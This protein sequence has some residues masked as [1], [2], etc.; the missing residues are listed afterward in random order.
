M[1]GKILACQKVHIFLALTMY[2]EISKDESYT[3]DE[4]K[5]VNL[6]AILQIKAKFPK[7]KISLWE[8]LVVL[9]ILGQ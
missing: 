8:V 4:S 1:L 2:N 6:D 9:Q 7:L 5:S 3:I